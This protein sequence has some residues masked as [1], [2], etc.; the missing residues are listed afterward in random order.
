VEEDAQIPE[1]IPDGLWFINK[2]GTLLS[3]K[4]SLGGGSVGLF[5]G[6]RLGRARNLEKLDKEI[7][8]F[9]KKFNKYQT[10]LDAQEKQLSS[11]LEQNYSKELEALSTDF[12]KKVR[13][14]SVLEAREKE[15]REFIQR[16]GERSEVIEAK[17]KTLEEESL[18]LKPRLSTLQSERSEKTAIL[19]EAL[20][21]LENSRAELSE[22]SQ[23]F[24]QHNISYI[25]L[26]N[27]LENLEREGREK[28]ERLQNL[29]Q[30][31]TRLK[32]E[33]EQT[34]KD[35]HDLVQNNL[36]NDEEI[37]GMYEAKKVKEQ[38]TEKFEQIAA[39]IRNS[40]SQVD[41]KIR[42]ERK[43]RDDLEGTKNGI[44][45]QVTDIKIQLN[46]L[47]ERM[48]VEFEVDISDLDEEDLFEE[49]AEKHQPDQVE[50]QML[51]MRA[52]IQ[53]YGE[54]NPM[55]MEAF[56]EMKER[57]DF[58][59][60]Q[61]KDLEEARQTLLDTIAEIDETA[62]EK[63]EE[64][65]TQIRTNFKEVFQ[66]LFYEGDTCDL[67]LI[68]PKDP[69]ES[70]IDIMAKPKGKR[71]LT[72][73]QLSGGEKTLTAI[74]LLFVIYLLK[75]APFCVFDEV[76]APLDDANIDKFN[77]IIKTFSADSQF[78]IV[79]HNKRTM[80]ATNVMYGVTMQ[81][82]GVSRVLPVDLISL[83]LS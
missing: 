55:A 50:T 57:A 79:T 47:K 37:V 38:R 34:K 8:D 65:F 14:L 49:G 69:L 83:N 75:P 68:D 5:Q 80:A 39:T 59:E 25:Q 46:S 77:N 31:E 42:L 78:I 43:Q 76:D 35:I 18:N 22:Q 66:S 9:E 2:G 24:N 3:K 53:K 51:S 71:P 23:E 7:R 32:Q 15:Y 73:N 13:E 28:S 41:D 48:A 20:R 58:I 1:D 74:S 67:I 44:R 12:E 30:S 82:D 26:K 17:I 72:I 63:F 61:K 70:K 27:L 62:T 10:D 4:H 21:M 64:A 11:F 36:Q 29:Q 52:K 33:Y 16:A 19:E 6:K 45:E 40:I 56:D 60:E 81:Q 54:I